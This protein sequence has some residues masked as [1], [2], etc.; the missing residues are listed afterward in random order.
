MLNKQIISQYISSLKPRI[1]H[2]RSS[3]NTEES[4]RPVFIE[5]LNRAGSHK[6][7]WVIAEERLNNNKKPDASIKNL[8][9]IHG[10]YE[11]KSPDTNLKKEIHKKINQNYPIKNTIFENSDTCILYQDKRPV[12]EISGMWNNDSGPLSEL[13]ALF[14]SYESLD[15]KNFHKAQKQ[16]NKNLPDLAE[17]IRQELMK[18]NDN[19]TYIQK[20]AHLVSECQKFIN[21]YFERKNVE[22]WL[23]QH[24]LTEQIF[25]KVFDEQQY[26]KTNNISAAISD[27]E[28]EFLR[29][30]KREILKRIKPYMVPITSYGSNIV[31][32]NE[33]QLFLKKVY[34]DFY[35]SYNKKIAD[36]LGIIYTPNEI[37]KFIVR[38]TNQVLKKHFNKEL[39][40][41]N[42]HILDPATGTGT[43]VTE[44]IEYIYNQSDKQTLKYKYMNE[45]HANEISVL[46]YYVANL[47]IEY[48]Y[49]KLTKNN[50]HFPNLVLMDSLQNSGI[51]KGQISFESHTFLENQKK[52]RKQ[53]EK[54]IQ[55][56]LGNPPY[57]QHQRRFDDDNPNKKYPELEE[58]IKDTYRT[59]KSKK[60]KLS[61]DKYIYFLRWA[62]DRIRNQGVISFVVNR[63][64]LD[65]DSGKGV[66]CCLEKEFDH[67][68]ILDLGGNIRTGDPQDSNVFDIQTGIS[69]IFLV[70]SK[71]E[72]TTKE[73]KA[74]IE[75]IKLS[76]N[77]Y[78]DKKSYKL[79]EL[80]NSFIDEREVEG[81]KKTLLANHTDSKRYP[82][83]IIV[84]NKKYQWLNQ[85]THFEGFFLSNFFEKSFLGI[86]TNRDKDVYD[87]SKKELEKKM[88]SLIQDLKDNP[89]NPKIKLSRD[90]KSKIKKGVTSN[91]KFEKEKICLVGYRKNESKY[92]YSEKILS[93]VLTQNHFKIWGENLKEITPTLCWGIRKGIFE[94]D[95]VNKPISK[96]YFKPGGSG[97]RFVSA[98]NI[99]NCHLLLKTPYSLSKKEIFPYITG[100][101]LSKK[102]KKYIEENN[103][104]IKNLP[105]PLWDNYEEYIKEG[106]R[107]I[108]S[109][110]RRQKS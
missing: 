34:Q 8:Y 77:L 19:Q 67:I 33:R 93:D 44:L 58:R 97:T 71:I 9:T 28:K 32:L 15:I 12:S 60:E 63:S 62:T 7:L 54:D 96:D 81:V 30:K 90:L 36:R 53:N 2:I 23:V 18:M 75:Y 5:L 82:F 80:H 27:I 84:P 74:K 43:F 29:E 41:K 13:L 108:V 38:S 98:K 11:A 100:L 66:R 20:T 68:Y 25:L 64:F 105:I 50:E 57:N 107:R 109:L 72:E 35:N 45:I 22:D 95:L 49:E 85:E 10:Y 91:L 86:V 78:E 76:E 99:K 70:K 87:S 61:Q 65:A 59:V 103:F 79:A 31:D 104:D 26:H 51:L 3:Q 40:D 16:F 14:F 52:V 46:P 21:P 6:N 39:K 4:L 37:V 55:I 69:I 83:K 24:V 110:E 94:V 73:E 47:S 89:N 56:V 1:K 106:E 17:E 48:T 42:V 102:Y 88:K 101:F 92:F